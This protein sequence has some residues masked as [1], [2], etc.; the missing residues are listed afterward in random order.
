MFSE[1]QPLIGGL[2]NQNNDKNKQSHKSL[3]VYIIVAITVAVGLLS[4]VIYFYPASVDNS[5]KKLVTARLK[6]EYISSVLNDAGLSDEAKSD[7]ITSLPG[8]SVDINDLGYNMFSGY[9]DV[10]HTSTDGIDADIQKQLFYWLYECDCENADEQPLILWTN[11]GPGCSGMEGNLVEHGGLWIQSDLTLT[12]NEYSWNKLANMIYVEQPFGVGFS[13]PT[14]GEVVGGDLNAAMDMDS[15]LRHFLEKYPKYAN[16]KVIISSESWGGHY[17][18]MTAFQI[19][20]NNEKGKTP[21]INFD[22][23]LVGNP[24]TDYFENRIGWMEAL[25]GHGLLQQST[26]EDWRSLCYEK[27]PDLENADCSLNYIQSYID[28][29]SV[30]YYA[31]DYPSCS[32]IEKA[33][34]GVTV[35]SDTIESNTKSPE[36][37]WFQSFLT[38]H[39]ETLYSKYENDIDMTAD[40]KSKFQTA[41]SQVKGSSN[42]PYIACADEYMAKYFNQADVQ[43]ALHVKTDNAVWAMC[44]DAVY[45]AWTDS[46]YYN[47]MERVYRSIL[48]DFTTKIKI[49]IFSGDDDSVCGTP[50]TQYWLRNMGFDV[51]IDYDWK[52]WKV[53]DELAGFYTRFLMPNT[54]KSAIHFQT[55]RSAGHMVPQTQPKKAYRLLERY[56]NFYN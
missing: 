2:T 7:L 10:D 51:D 20:T 26:Y 48:E 28:S 38:R 3:I 16:N 5:T 39:V 43:E 46:D 18:P 19:L 35:K 41:L 25:Y 27:L 15:F 50:G 37:R 23:I 42:I 6:D 53:D 49:V 52:E 11:G 33:D 44:S 14:N 36:F 45:D 54:D 30:D 29:I 9:V 24:Y 56:L 12:Q 17:M 55:V 4:L 32:L 8:L 13:V 47:G 21:Y 1:T 22:G 34:D 31:L 40:M